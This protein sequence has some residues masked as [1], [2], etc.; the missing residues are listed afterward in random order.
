M[1]YLETNQQ[2]WQQAA[3][4]FVA[5][6]Y[7]EALRRVQRS[8]F[9]TFDATEKVIFNTL[10]DLSGLDA[11]QVGCNNELET[12]GLKKNGTRRC[13]GIDFSATFIAQARQLAAGSAV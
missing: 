3:D 5:N 10:F 2:M 13:V 7:A 6:G 1:D 9:N 4:V 8:D 12:I 11:I